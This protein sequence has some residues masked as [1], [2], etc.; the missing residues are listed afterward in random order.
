[1]TLHKIVEPGTT[2]FYQ[3]QLYLGR[4]IR[5]LI[6]IWRFC[7]YC[8][9]Q[10]LYLGVQKSNWN[11]LELAHCLC[12]LWHA[13]QSCRSTLYLCAIQ[14]VSDDIEFWLSPHLIVPPLIH[15]WSER[16]Q[17]HPLLL[18]NT[19]AFLE[20]P[21]QN[22]YRLLRVRR[23]PARRI[24]VHNND[25]VSWMKVGGLAWFQ[26]FRKA[27]YLACWCISS[28]RIDIYSDQYNLPVT[29]MPTPSLS[30][31]AQCLLQCNI[32]QPNTLCNIF[33]SGL[34]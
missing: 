31:A 16:R 28:G 14:F 13:P 18:H 1:M 6:V 24:S 23:L 8:A 15:F 33:L 25:K 22:Q 34:P 30:V 2:K 9:D 3:V 19:Q 17:L 26:P 32:R 29:V 5:S 7:T 10:S 12:A 21:T 11:H 20:L 27:T 4:E